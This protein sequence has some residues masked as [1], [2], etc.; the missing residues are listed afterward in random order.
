M[1]SEADDYLAALEEGY[2]EGVR[3]ARVE[4]RAAYLRGF[5]EAREAAADAASVG[6][7]FEC[8][9]EPCEIEQ[10]RVAR[11]RQLQPKETE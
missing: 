10:N 3:K 4:I 8:G 2:R 9:C 6:V 7:D 5:A 1:M 11:I